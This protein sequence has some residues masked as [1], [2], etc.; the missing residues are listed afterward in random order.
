MQHMTW[1]RISTFGSIPVV[2]LTVRYQ[3]VPAGLRSH[4]IEPRARHWAPR[5]ARV[6][7]VPLLTHVLSSDVRG[8]GPATDS[9]T[10]TG[11][12]AV[13]SAGFAAGQALRGAWP[14]ASPG[15]FWCWF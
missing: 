1:G 2:R 15:C 8:E 10:E 7:S 9:L 6:L 12:F 3:P 4:R 5:L 11:V 13:R 14:R